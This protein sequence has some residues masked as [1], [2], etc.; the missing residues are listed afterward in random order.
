MLNPSLVRET[1]M[2][3]DCRI[4][5]LAWLGTDL[6]SK[7]AQLKTHHVSLIC[8]FVR[9]KNTSLHLVKC[10]VSYPGEGGPYHHLVTTTP[11]SSWWSRPPGY[12]FHQSVLSHA[13]ES[14]NAG[15]GQ[16]WPLP[17][18]EIIHFCCFGIFTPLIWLFLILMHMHAICM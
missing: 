5:A 12:L 1:V 6:E 2:I 7:Q 14:V 4:V 13:V 16:T 11:C 3:D 10:H 17:Q 8:D 9:Q 15:I 18:R